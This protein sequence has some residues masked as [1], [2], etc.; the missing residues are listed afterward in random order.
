MKRGIFFGVLIIV[1]VVLLSGVVW[2]RLHGHLIPNSA[3]GQT[4]PPNLAVDPDS[5]T[6]NKLNNV[7]D[8]VPITFTREENLF[9]VR[10]D[11]AAPIPLTNTG[12]NSM[13]YYLPQAGKLLFIK[14]KTAQDI[15]GDVMSIDLSTGR[16]NII[17]PASV[18]GGSLGSGFVRAALSPEGGKLIVA[19]GDDIYAGFS[20]HSALPDGKDF[21]SSITASIPVEG[22]AFNP[23]GSGIAFENRHTDVR[24][25]LIYN[26]AWN[27]SPVPLI[28]SA[29]N[30]Y[31]ALWA[32]DFSWRPDGSAITFFGYIFDNL[33]E[34]PKNGIYEVTTSG[35]VTQLYSAPGKWIYNLHWLS[36]VHLAFIA[37][38]A[39]EHKETDPG[40]AEFCI[41]DTQTG[42]LYRSGTGISRHGE[43]RTTRILL[44]KRSFCQSPLKWIKVS[45]RTPRSTMQVKDT[46]V[47]SLIW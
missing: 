8:D 15:T 2:W 12:Y 22:C 27:N 40:D 19:E 3:T 13:P 9:S 36:D 47:E 35:S 11:G 33:A 21:S 28:T 45:K 5:E 31:H 20:L 25:T 4:S 38:P 41:F 43:C 1:V 46:S 32:E 44:G 39:S 6:T 37:M 23:D 17:L 30:D 7:G 18:L 14:T 42:Q 24:A 34:G 26:L 29:D 10:L 16:Q